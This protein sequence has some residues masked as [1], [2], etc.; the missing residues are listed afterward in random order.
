MAYGRFFNRNMNDTMSCILNETAV[1]EMGIDDPVGKLLVQLSG[2]PGKT[3]SHKIVGVVRDF[4][5]ETLENPIRPLVMLFLPGNY[6]GYMTVRLTGQN[7]DATVQNIKELWEQYT[8]AYPFVYYFL[9]EDRR[10]YYKPVQTTAR[11]FVLL[12]VVTTLMACLSLFA[13]VAFYYNRKQ[14]EIGIL[15]A[16]GASNFS[17]ILRRAGEIVVLV[18]TSSVVAWIGAYFLAN[19]WLKDYA[20]R[21]NVNVL[22]FFAATLVIALISLGTVYY[23]TFLA[24]RANPGTLLKY[25]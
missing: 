17:I 10:N 8:E 9:D 15:K 22:F 24:A 4:N 12:S 14:R 25:E 20:N 13:L 7:Q 19:F 21:I 23:H 6:E 1:K 18:L 11:I 3:K 16:M 5:F 2:K